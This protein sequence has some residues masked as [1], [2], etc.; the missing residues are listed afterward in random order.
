MASMVLKACLEHGD[1][2]H[3]LFIVRLYEAYLFCSSKNVHPRLQ[4]LPCSIMSMG[5]FREAVGLSAVDDLLGL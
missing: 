5:I 2:A 3:N 1:V 4:T